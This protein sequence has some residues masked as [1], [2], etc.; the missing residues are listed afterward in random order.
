MIEPEPSKYDVKPL[1]EKTE[2]K[3]TKKSKGRKRKKHTPRMD[4]LSQHYKGQEA[5]F[6][7]QEQFGRGREYRAKKRRQPH[8]KK[9]TV[10]GADR[11]A[12][13]TFAE[14]PREKKKSRRNVKKLATLDEFAEDVDA[15]V[16]PFLIDP[17][18]Q[19]LV[20]VT[21]DGIFRTDR[22][23][24]TFGDEFD[25]EEAD[26]EEAV[27]HMDPRDFS[28]EIEQG[29]ENAATQDSWVSPIPNKFRR[30]KGHKHLTDLKEYKFGDESISSQEDD[31][32]DISEE[33]RASF[34]SRFDSD[35]DSESASSVSSKDS[36]ADESSLEED[37]PVHKRHSDKR[38]T[39]AK[40]TGSKRSSDRKTTGRK[41]S[42]RKSS[43]RKTSDK[44]APAKKS[45]ERPSKSRKSFHEKKLVDLEETDSEH[46]SMEDGSIDEESL[47]D[48]SFDSRFGSEDSGD[49]R[50]LDTESA[51]E[52]RSIRSASSVSTEKS[53]EEESSVDSIS[54]EEDD[55]SLDDKSLGDRSLDDRSLDDRSLDRSLD[56]DDEKFEFCVD[57]ECEDDYYHGP[58]G[59]DASKDRELGHT[60]AKI[61]G[62][63]SKLLKDLHEEDDDEPEKQLPSRHQPLDVET[64]KI[65]PRRKSLKDLPDPDAEESKTGEEKE[66]TKEEKKR[67]KKERKAKLK[68]MLAEEEKK[69]Q[70]KPFKVSEY[71]A[72][73]LSQDY[74][75]IG[76]TPVDEES[77]EELDY[78]Q[79][80]LDTRKYD[81][82][83]YAG[84]SPL[85]W[86]LAN[87][88]VDALDDWHYQRQRSNAGRYRD[89]YSSH[90]TM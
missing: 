9:D 76:Q 35:E 69:E 5:D 54:A 51:D 60:A 37:K 15:E 73:L 65:D 83:F 1:P 53:M 34:D 85:A 61:P 62:E 33:S 12:K 90:Y 48:G 58:D 55:R 16:K 31:L 24:M 38:A 45:S 27:F 46:E 4:L 50:S 81:K 23:A 8:L 56:E 47:S 17:E 42:E 70:E 26:D 84:P 49:D 44:K 88:H 40:P 19:E 20:P 43:E 77:D 79:K 59:P 7:E 25:D 57:S 6:D 67:L 64:T 75:F 78:G 66:L 36:L 2:K 13:L 52:S 11:M 30:G 21:K 86:N 32:S 18:D 89:G 39:S 74:D 14:S 72:D 68:E 3:R 41:S 10:K 87:S 71:I 22:Q 82:N 63:I 29:G 28:F 80:K